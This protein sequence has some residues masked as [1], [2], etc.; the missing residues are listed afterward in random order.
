MFNSLI[1]NL[2]SWF[3][4]YIIRPLT[5]RRMVKFENVP[6]PRYEWLTDEEYVRM[7]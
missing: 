6:N 3:H 1:W 7:L 2:P 5:G 4:T